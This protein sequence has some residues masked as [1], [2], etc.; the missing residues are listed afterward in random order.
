M[1]PVKHPRVDPYRNFKFRVKLDGRVVAGVNKVSALKRTTE[2][3]K[4]TGRTSGE[5][6]TLGRGVTY[7]NDFVAWATRTS[8]PGKGGAM[9]AI[10]GEFKRD[11]VIEMLNEPG[12][13]AAA[14]KLHSCWA[15]EFQALP[16]LDAAS[17]NAILI[18]TLQL[19][20]ESWERDL[21]VG[22]PDEG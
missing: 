9:K 11:L 18:E 15:S 7:D 14:Y 2:K 20:L 21:S 6:V 8:V 10:P 3:G 13:V 1:S 19:E 22:E 16:D 17:A 12:R 5:P 4:A